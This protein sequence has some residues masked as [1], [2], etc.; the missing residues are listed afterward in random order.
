VD[1][2]TSKPL[3]FGTLGIHKVYLLLKCF[4]C[5]NLCALDNNL[6]IFLVST[7]VSTMFSVYKITTID[8]NRP[9]SIY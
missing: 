6:I 7:E 4:I 3:P 5:L 1:N 8:K 9:I 2:K